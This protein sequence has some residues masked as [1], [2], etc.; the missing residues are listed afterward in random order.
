[1]DL[2]AESPD[3]S[4]RMDGMS[5]SV[6]RIL[7]HGENGRAPMGLSKTSSSDQGTISNGVDSPI[8]VI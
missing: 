6:A 5:F 3:L 8:P 2:S 4:S 1:M 7:V